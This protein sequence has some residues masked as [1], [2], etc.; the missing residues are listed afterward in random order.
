MLDE[1][2]DEDS[3][4]SEES[5]SSHRNRKRP[6]QSEVVELDDD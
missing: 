3:F 4:P 6:R 2:I 1:D 5:S